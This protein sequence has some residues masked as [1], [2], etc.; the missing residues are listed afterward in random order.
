MGDFNHGYY[1]L[2]DIFYHQSKR[3]AESKNKVQ[4]KVS[5]KK[6]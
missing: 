5:Q 3:R 1:I 6:I 4:E 2:T